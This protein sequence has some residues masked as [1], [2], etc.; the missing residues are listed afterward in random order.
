MCTEGPEIEDFDCEVC[1][2]EFEFDQ[3]EDY[4][5]YDKLGIDGDT[6]DGWR[7]GM[8][9]PICLKCLKNS[10]GQKKKGADKK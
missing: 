5:S 7:N 8:G 10:E 4:N 2:K 6:I 3:A 9:A 1:G